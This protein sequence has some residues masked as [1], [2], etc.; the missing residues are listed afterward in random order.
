MAIS[1]FTNQN[2]QDTYKRVVQTDG[3]NLADG[4]GSLL[5][6]S[7]EGN[8]V[9]I[10]GAVRANSYIVSESITVVTSG[11]TVF[12]NSSEDTHTFIG[13]ITSSDRILISGSANGNAK[14]ILD[15]PGGDPSVNFYLQGTQKAVI[16]HDQSSTY[17]KFIAGTSLNNTTGIVMADTGRIGIGMIPSTTFTLRVAN[18]IAINDSSATTSLLISALVPVGQDRFGTITL[19][20]NANRQQ[21]HFR[22]FGNSGTSPSIYL[23][24]ADDDIIYGVDQ[25]NNEV[26]SISQQGLFSGT[27]NLASNLTASGDISAS[28]LITGKINTT[29]VNTD[30]AHYFMLQTAV[31]TLPLISNGMNLNPS[32][33]VLSVGGGIYT[34][35]N[36]TASIIS[37]SNKLIAGEVHFDFNSGTKFNYQGG[38]EIGTNGSLLINEN[39]NV[40]KHITASGNISASGTLIANFADKNDDN[41]YYPL[42]ISSLGSPIESQNSLKV[43]PGTSEVEVGSLKSFG[44]ITASGNISAS[45]DLSITGESFFGSHITASGNISSSGNLDLTGNANIDGTITIAN[46]T[47]IQGENASG[48]LRDIAYVGSG[49]RLFLGGTSQG[50]TVQASAGNLILDSG[51]DITI[52]ADSGNVYFKDNTQTSVTVNTTTGHITSSGNISS[53]HN[54][55][56]SA[57]TGSFRR[58]LLGD[59]N[60]ATLSAEL[61]IRNQGSVNINLDSFDQNGNQI[62]NFL[63]NQEPDFS[64]GNYFSDGGFQIRSDQK[65]FAKFGADDGDII[66]LSG[67]LHVTGSNGHIITDGNISASGYISS[68]EINVG[69]GTFTSASLAAAQASG[70]NLGNHTATQNLNLGNFDITS[71]KNIIGITGS[72][73]QTVITLK[74]GAQDSPFLIKIAD[75]NGQDNKLEMT[76]DGILKF[77]ALDTL[78]TAIT[79]GLAYSASAFYAGL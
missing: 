15:D 67:S 1:D 29:D 43:N 55:K 33:D 62:I 34:P 12:G 56:V 3:T 73:N 2:I 51:G 14:L 32:N 16:G 66:E 39:L 22:V 52:E 65:R 17:N 27:C 5:P 53:S 60:V 69:G 10:P 61:H 6:I 4:S 48:F 25:N 63:N 28:G 47:K 20:S 7:F 79:G 76:K 26:W 77:G 31:D 23:G 35:L 58:L 68:S 72:F 36:I 49:N 50:T 70:D 11:S 45:G 44:P 46:D 8:D 38:N 41:L 37:A 75:S 40:E 64:I 19:P 42:V 57:G 18:G 13:S 78:P 71:S 24:D 59:T 9:I 54:S 74:A 21:P 30:A